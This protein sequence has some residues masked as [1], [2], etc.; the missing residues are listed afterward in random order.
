MTGEQHI[1]PQAIIDKVKSLYPDA[2]I[3]ILGEGCNLEMLVIS[4]A[5]KIMPVMKRQQSILKLFADDLTSGRLHALG[6]RAK[7]EAEIAVAR[8]GFVQ[9]ET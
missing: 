8:S 1:E 9:L 5:F 6:V 3:E 4:D 7:T 2:R